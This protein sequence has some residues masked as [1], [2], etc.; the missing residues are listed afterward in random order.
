MAKGL[1]E[2]SGGTQLVSYHGPGP[3]MTPDGPTGYSSSFWFH[4]RDWLDYN[5]IQSGHRWAVKNYEY[6]THDYML[7]PVKPVIDMEARYENHPD[8]PNAT[9]RMDAHQEREAAYWSMLA[10]AAGHGYGCNDIWQFYNPDR[11]PAADDKSFPFAALRGNTIWRQAMD[12]D[13][14]Y[15]MGMMRKLFE[16]RPWYKL[17]PDQSVIVAGQGEGEDRVGAGRATDGSFLLAY[18]TFGTP[19]SVRMDAISGSTVKAQAIGQ[20]P[21]RGTREFVS[22]RRG[23]QND[24]VLV[25]EDARKRFPVW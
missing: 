14:A 18:S 22:P 15:H 17:A 4:D 21:N 6:V 25:L 19:F 24:W 20:F 23:P 16:A 7:T 1:K 3:R 8:G 12:F 2:G 11:M 13:G 5:V 9:R 10:G